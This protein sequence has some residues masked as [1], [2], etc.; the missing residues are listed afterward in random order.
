[1]LNGTIVIIDRYSY[2]GAVYSAAKQNELLDFDWAWAPEIGLPRPD[3]CLFLNVSA[4]IASQRGGYGNERYENQEMQ[5]SVREGFKRLI[6]LPGNDEFRIVDAGRSIEEVA[7]DI[8]GIVQTALKHGL[9][10]RPLKSLGALT[11]TAPPAPPVE[12]YEDLIKVSSR[13]MSQLS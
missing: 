9:H 5:G 4:E 11:F 13:R 10:T 8:F 7:D 2:S 6:E 3:L 1:M 12:Q